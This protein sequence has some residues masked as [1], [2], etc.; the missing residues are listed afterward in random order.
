M[1]GP[2]R[3]AYE[4]R[5]IGNDRV[6]IDHATN[7]MWQ[8]SGSPTFGEGELAIEE[9]IGAYLDQQNEQRYADFADWRLPTI[10]ELASLMEPRG[11]VDRWFIDSIFDRRVRYCLSADTVC[12]KRP[13]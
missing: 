10:E 11:S 9:R 13:Q 12:H 6:V 7:L 4:V 5:T 3:N 2:W 1:F 8:Q